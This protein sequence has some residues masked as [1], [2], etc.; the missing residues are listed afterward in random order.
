MVT[1][2]LELTGQVSALSEPRQVRKMLWCR[3]LLLTVEGSSQPAEGLVKVQFSGEH[4]ALLDAVQ[5]GKRVTVAILI[6]GVE[7]DWEGT[8][9][10]LIVLIGHHLWVH[11]SAPRKIAQAAIMPDEVDTYDIDDLD[12][13]SDDTS[14]QSQ[15][16]RLGSGMTEPPTNLKSEGSNRRKDAVRKVDSPSPISFPKSNS[17]GEEPPF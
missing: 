15:T 11:Q 10:H 16:I 9:K 7:Y 13:I 1:T 6:R 14:F 4:M 3:D 17:F 12:N 5:I 2:L 8:T